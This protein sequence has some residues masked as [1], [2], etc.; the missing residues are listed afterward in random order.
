MKKNCY[1]SGILRMVI[2]VRGLVSTEEDVLEGSVGEIEKGYHIY[3]EVLGV[4]S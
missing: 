4:G 3:I 1:F 2:N